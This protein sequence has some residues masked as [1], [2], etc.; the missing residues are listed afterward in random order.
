MSH[1]KL[2]KH[3]RGFWKNPALGR[4]A[5]QKGAALRPGKLGGHVLALPFARRASQAAPRA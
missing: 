5:A 4:L 3:L 1:G 2:E